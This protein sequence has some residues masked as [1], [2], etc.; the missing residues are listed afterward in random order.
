MSTS[1]PS[2]PYDVLVV[3][4]GC[5]GLAAGMYAGRFGL[6]TAVIGELPGG[7]ITLTHIVENYPGFVSLT[8]QELADNLLKHMKAYHVPLLQEKALSVKKEKELFVVTTDTGTHRARA[9]IAATGTEWK[10]LNVPGEKE[11]ANKGVHYCALC[12][13]NFY[14]NKVIATVGSGDSA[15]KEGLY[16]A[17]L[18]SRAY[19]ITRGPELHGEPINNAR[20]REHKKLTLFNNVSVKEILGANG[21]ITGLKLSKPVP[22]GP[23]DAKG[24]PAG[25][26]SD[27]LPVDAL[28]VEIGH[29]AIADWLSGV[30]VKLNPKGEIVIDRLTRTSVSG[31]FAAGDVVDTEFKQAITGAAEGVTAA[32]SAYEYV[33]KNKPIC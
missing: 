23:K 17:D 31:L 1:S 6:K 16:L 29:S 2:Q 24:Q 21:K 12:D 11:Y 10:K 15:A 14:K 5:A 8:G 7:T 3:G 33:S 30:G 28:F 25:P 4:A 32:Y 19:I 20:V 27:V 13:G 18:S 9:L 26:L 22:T